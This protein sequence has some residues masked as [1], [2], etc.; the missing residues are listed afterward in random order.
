MDS[1]GHGPIQ[2]AYPHH[3]GDKFPRLPVALPQSQP[4]GVHAHQPWLPQ[5]QRQAEGGMELKVTLT[6][7][8]D[9]DESECP[10]AVYRRECGADVVQGGW[11]QRGAKIC[12]DS[13]PT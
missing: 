8:H 5:P 7:T 12:T 11:F 1:G 10:H 13:Q 2:P 9:H 4:L 3:L 6:I